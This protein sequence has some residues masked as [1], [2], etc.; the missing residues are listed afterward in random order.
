MNTEEAA[1]QAGL[2]T[3]QVRW[4]ARRG[5]IA[6]AR[7]VSGTRQQT[8]EIPDDWQPEATRTRKLRPQQREDLDRRLTAGEGVRKLAREYEVQPSYVSRRRKKLP[9]DS[10]NPSPDGK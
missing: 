7:L 1:R 6:G 9:E 10:E 8:W 3:A 5:K 4:L 2:S